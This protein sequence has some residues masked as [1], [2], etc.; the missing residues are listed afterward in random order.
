MSAP[1]YGLVLAGGL[2]TRM[3]ADKAKLTYAG[4]TQ[5]A[6]AYALAAGHTERAFVSVRESQTGDAER[7]AYPLLIDSLTGEGP[8]IGI[9]SALARHPRCAWLVIACD[10][11]F[12]SDAVLDEL[13]RQRDQTRL[14]TA[15]KSSHDG[16]PEP[17]CAVWEPA[18]GA[19]LERYQTGGGACPRKFLMRESALL[20]T[21]SERHALDN[22]N[23]PE[24][25][26]AARSALEAPSP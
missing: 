24:E 4:T 20:L 2:S 1:L 16:L 5:L 13:I 21:P 6:R 15:F 8:I 14:A 18:A 22:I 3:Q 19:A 12:L 23:T 9:R 17:L 10:L 26:A 11:P 25:Y 7:A